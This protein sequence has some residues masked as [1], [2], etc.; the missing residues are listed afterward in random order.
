MVHNDDSFIREVNEELRS[1]Q[2]K[3]V[4]RRFG[5]IIVALAVLVVVGTAAYRGY[6]YWADSRASRSGD[7]FLAALQLADQDKLDEAKKALADL[8]A[9]GSGSY[10]I[11]SKMRAASLMAQQGDKKGAIDAFSAI[12]NDESVPEAIRNA[13][14]LRAGWLLVETGTYD[15]VSAEV[16]VLAVAGN[17]FR[18]SARELLGLAAFKAGDYGK[19]KEWFDAIENDNETP[20]NIA[21]RAKMLLGVIAA[22]GKV[23]QG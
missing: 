7:Q 17:S 4:W 13:A 11:L 15:Q 23:A 6:E 19:A 12:G 14:K 22:S 5:R 8:E 3:A 18:H 20:A 21:N 2:M 16:E 9:N 1:D 10:P